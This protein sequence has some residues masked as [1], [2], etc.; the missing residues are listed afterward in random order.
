MNATATLP[1]LWNPA[2]HQAAGMVP[3]LHGR[4]PAEEQMAELWIEGIPLQRCH[5]GV[6][7]VL[8]GRRARRLGR[9]AA[10]VAA[11][12][13]DMAGDAGCIHGRVRSRGGTTAGWDVSEPATRMG[14]D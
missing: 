10:T 12:R 4:D 9:A 2:E 1:R 5:G 14:S 8:E 3:Y 6:L 11:D 13:A 7:R